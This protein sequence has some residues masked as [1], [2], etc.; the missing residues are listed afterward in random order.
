MILTNQGDTVDIGIWS[1]VDLNVT[2]ICVCSVTIKP[3]L[4]WLFPSS[5]IAL[6]RMGWSK[7]RSSHF[8]RSSGARYDR[9]SESNGATYNSF[10]NLSTPAGIHYRPE[11][12]KHFAAKHAGV[13]LRTVRT[14]T[15]SESP[16][17]MV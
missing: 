8:L 13:P 6:T 17:E 15:R 12:G 5:L 16:E 3:V 2:V 1:T 10:T 11:Q 7:L 4:G 14:G 9:Q